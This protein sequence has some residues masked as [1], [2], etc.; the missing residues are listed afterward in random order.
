[1]G[2][3]KFYLPASSTQAGALGVFHAYAPGSALAAEFDARLGSKAGLISGNPLNTNEL[4]YGWLRDEQG[5]ILDEVMLGCP[6]E[7][8]RVL[9]THGGH[10]VRE[11]VAAYLDRLGY[12]LLEDDNSHSI[13]VNDIL[14]DTFLASCLTEAQAAVVLEARATGVT[15]PTGLLGAHRVVLAG[16]PNAGKSSLLNALCGYD[17]AFVHERAGATRDVVDELVDL[18]GFAIW[19]G[20]MPGYGCSDDALDREAWSRAE[21]R[22]RL[23]EWIWLVVDA[24]VPWDGASEAAARQVAEVLGDGGDSRVLV[25]LNKSDLP[26]RL[27]G[28]PWRRFLPHSD[29][30]RVSS[31]RDNSALE[32]MLQRVMDYF[33]SKYIYC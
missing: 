33:G 15:P 28:E 12:A 23:A 9:M 1:M 7:G 6:V 25:L 20:D 27:E 18:A 14:Y 26:P 5:R 10:A 30:V 22:L 11:A 29:A 13:P 19:L 3:A 24:S 32:T 4:R 8:M 31:L 21:E 17:R 16:A 2:S